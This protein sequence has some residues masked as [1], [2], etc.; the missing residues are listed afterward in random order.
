MRARLSR[1]RVRDVALF[2]AVAA[3]VAVVGVLLAREAGVG[4]REA[5]AEGETLTLTLSALEICETE[6]AR[7]LVS[8]LLRTN[9]EGVRVREWVSQGWRV[10]AETPVTWR[11]SGGTAPYTLVIDSESRDADGDY[12][13]AVG[14]AMVSCAAPSVGTYF[15]A[16]SRQE[17]MTRLY[18]EDPEVDSGVKTIRAVVTDANGRTAEAS[19]DVYVIL[20]LGSTGDILRRGQT[21]RV[22]GHL[23]T[24]PRD[25]DVRV[26]GGAERECFEDDPDPRCGETTHGYGLVGAYAWISL[27]ASDGALHDR[28]PKVPDST[29]ASGASADPLTAAIDSMVGSLGKLPQVEANSQ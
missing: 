29:G 16:V 1:L 2:V 21:Y 22:R 13:G 4:G 18:R 24:A 14:K 6:R 27:Y 8:S 11:V 20:D 7:N 12:L 15:E 25:Y 28:H 23:M 17:G 10:F 26:G 5:I 9:E 19:V 3:V